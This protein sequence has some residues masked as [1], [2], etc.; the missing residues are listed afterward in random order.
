M[1]E[2]CEKMET[3]FHIEKKKYL[4]KY[5]VRELMFRKHVKITRANSNSSGKK[6]KKLTINS[7]N[8]ELVFYVHPK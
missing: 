6:P 4:Q 1:V 2:T 8:V 3:M 7:K 5:S